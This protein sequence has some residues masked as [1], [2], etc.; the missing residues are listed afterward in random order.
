MSHTEQNDDTPP[1]QEATAA[2]AS[3]PAITGPSFAASETPVHDLT[4]E[5]IAAVERAPGEVVKCRRIVGNYYRCNW[6]APLDR[7]E[8]AR[9]GSGAL[10]VTT[11]RVVKSR[12]LH[13]TRSGARLFIQVEQVQ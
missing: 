5:I 6:W 10:L 11:Q 3:A 7:A 9:G 4:A 2:Q 8:A 13:V 1:E 12:L